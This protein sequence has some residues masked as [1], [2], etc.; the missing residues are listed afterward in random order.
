MI[1]LSEK[2]KCIS[3]AHG[4][5]AATSSVCPGVISTQ[6]AGANMLYKSPFLAVFLTWPVSAFKVKIRGT[7]DC[8]WICEK[9]G[10]I[11]TH[12][13]GQLKTLDHRAAEAALATVSPRPRAHHF[14]LCLQQGRKSCPWGY[15]APRCFGKIDNNAVKTSNLFTWSLILSTHSS[16]SSKPVHLPVR[17]Q[18]RYLHE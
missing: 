4:K 12:G 1:L 2:S 17:C 16:A 10:L 3:F 15:E 5:E 6:G 9:I 14:S 8:H 13:I 7:S 11:T 18:P